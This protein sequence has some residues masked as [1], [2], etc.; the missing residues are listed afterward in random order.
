MPRCASSGAIDVYKRQLLK[1][2]VRE[3]NLPDEKYKP[4][5]LASR[6][7]YAKNCLV[8]PGADVYKRQV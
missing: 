5:L 3:L 2:I 1:T 6:I 7:S 4:N 8:T